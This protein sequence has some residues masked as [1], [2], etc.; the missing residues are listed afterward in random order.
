MKPEVLEQIQELLNELEEHAARGVPI[1]VEG[2]RDEEALRELG[3]SGRILC[4]SGT[5]KTILNFLEGLVAHEQVVILTDFDRAGNE[6]A[7]F[8]ATHLKRLGSEP[9]LEVREKLKALL[10]KDVKDI[11]GLAKFLRGKMS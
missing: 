6:L 10:H 9:I 8:C 2:P 11:Q 4:V 1:L 5:R 7:K 3:I